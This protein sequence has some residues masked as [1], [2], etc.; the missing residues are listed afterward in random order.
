MVPIGQNQGAGSRP[1][2]EVKNFYKLR[3]NFA[4]ETDYLYLSFS[5]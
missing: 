3:R 4:Q 1:K 2:G 5:L